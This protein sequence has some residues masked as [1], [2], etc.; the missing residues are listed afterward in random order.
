VTLCAY[1][2]TFHVPL[3]TAAAH[4]RV[5]ALARPAEGIGG[6]LALEPDQAFSG[7]FCARWDGPRSLLVPRVGGVAETEVARITP[8]DALG[9]LLE[10]SA[11]ALVDGVRHRDA[12][13]ALLAALANTS[14]AFRV[15][16]GRDALERPAQVARR[17]LDETR[18]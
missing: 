1:P 11:L 4:E 9:A 7:A 3:A 6:K 18:P 17:V 12:N 10:S 15:T 14:A 16:L 5:L 2:R 13:L 8:A